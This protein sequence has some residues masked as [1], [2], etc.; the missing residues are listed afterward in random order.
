MR[1][2][3]VFQ[4]VWKKVVWATNVYSLLASESRFP[5]AIVWCVVVGFSLLFP[6]IINLS[7]STLPFV[8]TYLVVSLTWYV[9]Q[10]YLVER[11]PRL[12]S[13]LY[14]TTS[15]PVYGSS[16]NLRFMGVVL[17]VHFLVILWCGFS[18]GVDPSWQWKQALS[19]DYNDWHPIL[20][21]FM[22]YIASRIWANPFSVWVMQI[23]VFAILCGWM[24]VT[25]KRMGLRASARRLLCC[26]VA[27]SPVSLCAL[28]SVTKDVAFAQAVLGLVLALCNIGCTGGGWLRPWR[29]KLLLSF[30]M[31]GTTYFRHN[32]LL[33]S[34][35][36]AIVFISMVRR[37]N[38]VTVLLSFGMVVIVCGGYWELRLHLISKGVVRNPEGQKYVE[39]IGLPLAIIGDAF[40]ADP[41]ALTKES[42]EFCEKIAPVETW[43][44]YYRGFANG[45]KGRL[46]LK[47]L[48]ECVPPQDFVMSVLRIMKEDPKH[49][50]KAIIRVTGIGWNPFVEHV[51][52]KLDAGKNPLRTT[53]FNALYNLL[54]HPPL[55]WVLA[56]PG[57]AFCCM[58]LI[59]GICSCKNGV[60]SLV[61]C[62]GLLIY[63]FGTA[64]LMYDDGRSDFRFFYAVELAYPIALV[65]G[66]RPR[67]KAKTECL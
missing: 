55:G 35:P 53:D 63:S 9:A 5:R 41:N 11:L 40:V 54:V 49:A 25:M 34:V 58:L 22:F 6:M 64:L 30:L 42:R 10:A 65:W 36:I 26:F 46:N 8:F 60:S 57:F 44:M 13:I 27:F 1:A 62:I 18:L 4:C 23:L 2:S 20:H 38:F 12:S 19:G 29:N 14:P 3:K 33:V 59:G 51:P 28:R 24:D 16:F 43:K 31:L 67:I 61:P 37:R 56:T 21:T 48:E 66:V 15:S 32:G 17:A 45:I 47:Y 7:T 39:A 52:G 50:F